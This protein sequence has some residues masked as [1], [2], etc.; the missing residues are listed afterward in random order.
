MMVSAETVTLEASLLM[1]SNGLAP[2]VRG[3]TFYQSWSKLFQAGSY[4]LDLSF[5]P[6]G[7]SG[8]LQ[9]QVLGG[10]LLGSGEVTLYRGDDSVAAHAQLSADGD[11]CLRVAETRPYRLA[12]MVGAVALSVGEL[13]LS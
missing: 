7:N 6:A 12:V 5:L 10:E 13:A 3:A 9:G 1:E 2:A 8:T 4:Y 11:F